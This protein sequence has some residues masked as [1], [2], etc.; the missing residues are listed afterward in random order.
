LNLTSL[1]FYTNLHVVLKLHFG[2]VVLSITFWCSCFEHCTLVLSFSTSHYSLVGLSITL[3]FWG[4]K[5]WENCS[6][7]LMFK[8]SSIT[9]W[10]W[11][12]EH[13]ILVLRFQASY[14]NLENLN[15]EHCILVLKLQVSSI[16]ILFSSFKNC[17]LV[18]RLWA[19]HCDLQ[20]LCTHPMVLRFW[21]SHFGIKVLNTSN[22]VDA[23]STCFGL[24]VLN[25]NSSL[26]VSKNYILVWRFSFL[27]LHVGL[28]IMII[29]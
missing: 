6:L 1:K 9:F 11:G 7:V 2:L 27:A 23:S 13:H 28:H 15:F 22:G 29:A 17:I 21:A 19:F 18:F 14:F 5:F 25:T 3:W 24:K 10:Y 4:F 20:G 16:K 12:F 26:E 8:I